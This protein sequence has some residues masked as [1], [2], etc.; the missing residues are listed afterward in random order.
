[1]KQ[2]R[3]KINIIE[4]CLTYLNYRNQLTLWYIHN[5]QCYRLKMDRA[6]LYFQLLIF[7]FIFM[8]SLIPLLL[9]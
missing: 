2:K 6:N 4:R 1:M 5:R 7:L 9:S 3:Y 8:P